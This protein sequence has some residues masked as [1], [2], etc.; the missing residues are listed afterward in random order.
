MITKDAETLFLR[1][2]KKLFETDPSQ[3]CLYFRASQLDQDQKEWLPAIIKIIREDFLEGIDG[4]YLCHDHDLFITGRFWTFK[5]LEQ[6]LTHLSPQLPPASS[7]GLASLFEVGVHWPQIRAIC[8]KKI[9]NLHLLQQRAKRTEEQKKHLEAVSREEAFQT[10]DPE[11]IRSL[12]IRRAR[13]SAVEIMVVEDD[14]FSQKLIQNAI[15]KQYP[16]SITGDGQGAV[17]NYVHKAP[18]VLFLDI[19]LPDI[20]GHEVLKRIF[21]IDPNAYV[22]MFSGS[23]HK[24]NI[25]KA[26]GVGARGFVGKP[27]TKDKLIQYI[28]KSPFIQTKQ[29]QEA[30]LWT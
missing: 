16:V 5:R 21:E 13:R 17:L 12:A 3:R 9:E 18:D 2:G 14:P 27:F 24:D 15:G 29:K 4:L 26:M 11:L 8:E 28:E 10:I 22:V 6:F 23:G 19:G 7:P 1:D 20:D 25:M 30:S